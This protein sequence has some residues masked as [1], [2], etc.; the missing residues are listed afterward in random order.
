MLEKPCLIY[1]RVLE[2]Y[3]V[4]HLLDAR[5]APSDI[6]ELS[7]WLNLTHST[8]IVTYCSVGYR[9]AILTQQLQT[10][11]YTEVYNLDGSIFEWINEGKP[12]YQGKQV[13]NQI[14]PFNQIWKFLLSF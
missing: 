13:V 1:A 10:I 12:V 14:H 11:G 5:L 4:S 6:H 7:C 8:F 2:E 9:S 3:E